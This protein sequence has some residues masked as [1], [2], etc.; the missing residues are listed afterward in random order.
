MPHSHL[1]AY[2]IHALTLRS[3]L[4]PKA[5]SLTERDRVLKTMGLMEHLVRVND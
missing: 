3:S 5:K 1:I 4:D 2:G